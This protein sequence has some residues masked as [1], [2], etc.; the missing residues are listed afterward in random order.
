MQMGHV[1]NAETI[2]KPI[3]TVASAGLINSWLPTLNFGVN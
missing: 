3:P 1:V 2:P